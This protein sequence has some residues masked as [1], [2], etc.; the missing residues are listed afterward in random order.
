M[1]VGRRMRRQCAAV[2]ML[3]AGTGICQDEA[4]PPAPM[5][6][7]DARV[8]LYRRLQ[9][10]ALYGPST[11][12]DC[13]Q[14]HTERRSPRHFDF[15]ITL[16]SEEPCAQARGPYTGVDEFR[17]FR[18]NGKLM[19]YFEEDARFVDYERAKDFRKR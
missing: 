12:M 10:D 6:E 1:S 8:L 9:T 7:N 11:S 18:A 4:A 5:S 13:V 3:V 14:F 2:L 16:K 15:I 17:V 19:W